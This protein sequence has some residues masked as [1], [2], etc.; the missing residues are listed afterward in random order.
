MLHV[1]PANQTKLMEP[2]VSTGYDG[3]QLDDVLN[4]HRHYGD[5]TEPNDD[6]PVAIDMGPINATDF[7]ALTNVSIDDNSDIDIFRLDLTERAALTFLVGPDAAQYRTGPQTQSC[8]GGTLVDYRSI[9]DLKID[10]YSS[11]NL[12]IPLAS[13][14]S[15]GAGGVDTLIVDLEDAGLYYVIVSAAS[16]VNNVQRYQVTAFTQELP[17]VECPADLTGDGILDFFDISAFLSAYNGMNPDADF[18][19]DGVYNFFDVSTFL[20]EF[21]AG[22]P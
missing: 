17:P 3:P 22:C 21:N 2:F 9:Q 7:Y 13:A 12:I 15:E 1:C 18:N 16:N 14:N 19:N 4:G 10:I 8:S 11:D 20:N 5:P 6:L